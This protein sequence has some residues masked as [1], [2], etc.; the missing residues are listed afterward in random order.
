MLAC[1]RGRKKPGEDRNS[2]HFQT[3][4]QAE[5]F[6]L[7]STLSF[8]LSTAQLGSFGFNPNAFSSSACLPARLL[9]KA[10][11]IWYACAGKRSSLNRSLLLKPLAPTLSGLFWPYP[12]LIFKHGKEIAHFVGSSVTM[13]G[14]DVG[15]SLY[16]DKRV[17]Q[18]VSERILVK[19]CLPV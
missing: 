4:E 15:F 16:R 6:I 1:S 3:E 8:A 17:V 18:V 14:L 19:T 9:D 7:S 10:K 11:F 13:Q 12:H 5:G 2:Y